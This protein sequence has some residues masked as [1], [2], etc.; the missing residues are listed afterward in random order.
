MEVLTSHLE[1]ILNTSIV[2]YR[3][4]SGGDISAVFKIETKTGAYVLKCGAKE[5]T[6]LFEAEAQGLNLI[7]KTQ[8]IATPKV[9]AVGAHHETPYLLMEFI[10]SKTPEKEDYN[11]LGNQL[12]QFHNCYAEQFGLSS[13][14]FIGSLFQKNTPSKNWIDFY[15]INRLGVQFELAVSQGLLN[16][17]EIPSQKEIKNVLKSLCSDVKPS[18]LHGDLWSGNYIIAKDGTPYLI[19]PATY[20][21][22]AEVDIAMTKLFGGFGS[23][24]Y[25]AYH[26]VIPISNHYNERI[27]LYQLYYLLVHLN[28]FGR[29]Y[30]NSVQRILKRYF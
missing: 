15:S 26:D 21:G 29:S 3:P 18:L 12:A 22:H 1:D 8:T 25:E 14:N 2:S 4:L 20:Y 28:L 6:S 7:A 23:H 13:D 11:K 9:I 10:A 17:K 5:K 30:Y 27:D 24:F 16:P 19:D